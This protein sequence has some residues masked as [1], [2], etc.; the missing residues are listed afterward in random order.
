[1]APT[2][3]SH[4]RV[5]VVED[6]PE[7][8]HLYI[9]ILAQEGLEVTAV[10]DGLQAIAAASANPPD[11]V[12]LDLGLP[13]LGGL[14]VCRR[15]KAH[16]STHLVPVLIIT[17][18]DPFVRRV[19]AWEAGADEYLSK[20]VRT[21]DLLARVH[22]LLRL[23]AALDELDSANASLF[24][25]TRAVEA[26]CPY[27][28]GHTER[29]TSYSMRLAD[30]IGLPAPER[31]ALRR[32]AI[33]HDIGKIST[34]DAILNKPGRLTSDEFA[35]IK[36]HPMEGVRIIEPLRSLRSAL[37]FVRWHHERLNGRG[38]PDGLSGSEIPLAV[39]AL[40]VADVFDALASDRPY[41][42]A[43][44]KTECFT[45]MEE[46]AAGG[47]LDAELVHCLKE[48]QKVKALV[49]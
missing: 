24:A 13:G 29:V 10:R 21:A 6:D 30:A 46:D 27:T 25:F 20:P 14:D 47:G 17:G 23:K 18:A 26:K 7:I 1:M 31:E 35:M 48:L 8:T 19:G 36:R 15:L 11:L 2:I 12:L 37:P 33:L 38:Y 4:G 34:P 3:P 42:P 5:L 40:A 39:R 49:E 41:R 9:S 22:S 45:V 44:S 43:M 16:P 32:G 28:L